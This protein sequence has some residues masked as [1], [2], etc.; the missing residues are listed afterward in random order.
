MYVDAYKPGLLA[1]VL[2]IKWRLELED[3]REHISLRETCRKVEQRHPNMPNM[4]MREL[5]TVSEMTTLKALLA[6]DEVNMES[7]LVDD[8]PPLQELLG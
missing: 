5:F 2:W 6:D 1:F 4:T 8:V 7:P 3:L